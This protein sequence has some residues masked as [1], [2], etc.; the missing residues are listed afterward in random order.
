MLPFLQSH[1]YRYAHMINYKLLFFE[2]IENGEVIKD[3][4]VEVNLIANVTGEEAGVI[5]N[6]VLAAANKKYSDIQSVVDFI[7]LC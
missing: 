4:V 3:R 5:K 6:L 2:T 1:N 7:L